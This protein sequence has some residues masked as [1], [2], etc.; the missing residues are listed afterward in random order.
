MRARLRLALPALCWAPAWAQLPGEPVTDP[1]LLEEL[2][3]AIQR[4]K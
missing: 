4:N 1:G 3:R 2:R